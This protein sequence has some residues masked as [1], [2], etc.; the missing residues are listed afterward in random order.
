GGEFHSRVIRGDFPT[1][2]R[3]YSQTGRFRRMWGIMPRR[4]AASMAIPIVPG[5]SHRLTAPE[6]LSEGARAEFA[7]VVGAQKPA[8]FRLSDLGLLSQYCEAA[9]LAERAIKE[10][11]REGAGSKWLATWQVATKTMKDLA[12]RLR[13]CPQSRQPNNPSR[14]QRPLSYYEMQELARG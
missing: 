5:F 6:T 13:L 9:A 2:H 8:H 4:S 3:L 12:M 11:G 10:I 1:T 14:P 7:R